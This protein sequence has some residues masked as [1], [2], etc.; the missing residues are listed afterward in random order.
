MKMQAEYISA[1]LFTKTIMHPLA[2]I[3]HAQE[4]NLSPTYNQR[5]KVY[6]Y[7]FLHKDEE[8]KFT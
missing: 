2:L 1:S 4:R 8:K 5:K 3:L 7:N 6:K